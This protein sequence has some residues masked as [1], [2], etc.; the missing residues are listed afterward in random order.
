MEELLN[1][2]SKWLGEGKLENIL[3]IVGGVYA[4]LISVANLITMLMP[5]VKDNKVY[6]F[7]MKILNFIALNIL[8]NKN[9]DD[10]KS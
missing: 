6:N 5:S 8:K 3:I 10:T 1:L 9:A 4:L 2:V 7:V